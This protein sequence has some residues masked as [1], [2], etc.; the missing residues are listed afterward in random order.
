MNEFENL[1]YIY[2]SY[3]YIYIDNN[4]RVHHCTW[5]FRKIFTLAL[6][7]VNCKSVKTSEPMCVYSPRLDACSVRAMTPMHVDDTNRL[8][9]KRKHHDSLHHVRPMSK[10]D[11]G[12]EKRQCL[13]SSEKSRSQEY[14]DT[15]KSL[16]TVWTVE[17]PPSGIRRWEC[18]HRFGSQQKV[19]VN[20]FCNLRIMGRSSFLLQCL[21]DCHVKCFIFL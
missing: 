7:R 17:Q 16:N 5:S 3:V 20:L 11:V 12:G 8:K 18:E 6:H 4:I 13:W 2:L 9:R 21:P 15:L 19:S 1:N 10:Q 14:N